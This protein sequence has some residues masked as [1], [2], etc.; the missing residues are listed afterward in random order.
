MPVLGNCI[1]M[2]RDSLDGPP[3]EELRASMRRLRAAIPPAERSRLAE[4]VEEALFGLPGMLEARAVLLF[5]S[6]G[7][8]VA[9][10]GMA[11]RILRSG[12]RLFLPYLT[13]D[14]T[15]EAAEIRADE[16][17]QVTA[18][19]PREPAER[20][21][22]DPGAIDLVV[23]PGLAFDQRGNR[24]GYGG[25]NYDRYLARIGEAALRVG[26]AFSV[27]LVDMVPHGPDDER[28]HIVVTDQGVLDARP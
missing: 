5:Y 14:G 6:F 1:G 24:L 4:L 20:I 10:A 28:V 12:K 13:D 16:A 18:Y 7:T 19:G 22:I 2:A 25:G 26:V 11:Q 9:T 27:Q 3:K 8:E 21:P 15:M 23:T 17:L